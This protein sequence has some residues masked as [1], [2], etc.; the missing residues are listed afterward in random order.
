M[1]V[2]IGQKWYFETASMKHDPVTVTGYEEHPQGLYAL[3][4]DP[5]Q[6]IP[7]NKDYTLRFDIWKHFHEG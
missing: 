6:V 4:T 3:T 1:R 2:E 5:D 7:L